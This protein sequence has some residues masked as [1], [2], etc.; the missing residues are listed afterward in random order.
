[1]EPFLGK[2]KFLSSDNF[3]EYLKELGVYVPRIMDYLI[4]KKFFEHFTSRL[5]TEAY[6]KFYI[7][8]KYTRHET[9][10]RTYTIEYSYLYK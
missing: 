2:W 6:C 7:Q 4:T 8:Y 9:P 5:A 10:T 1:M 3:D